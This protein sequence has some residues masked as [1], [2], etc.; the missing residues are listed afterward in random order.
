V[1]KKELF[2]EITKYYETDYENNHN[3]LEFIRN[4]KHVSLTKKLLIK[5]EYGLIGNILYKHRYNNNL[6]ECIYKLEC[7]KILEL[8]K[9]EN[10]SI[11][12]NNYQENFA[13]EDYDNN[14]ILKYIDNS[15]LNDKN[16]MKEIIKYH[17]YILEYVNVEYRKDKEIILEVV[18][19]DGNALEYA[20]DELKIDK[21][22]VLEAIKQTE[23]ALFY[24]SQK[25]KQDEMFI[26]EIVKVNKT[27]IK[28]LYKELYNNKSLVLDIIKQD[29]ISLEMLPEKYKDDKEIVFEAVKQ[30]CNAFQYAADEL[31]ND[32]EFII[33][34]INECS[35]S[36]TILEHIDI[37]LKKDYSFLYQIVNLNYSI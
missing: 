20:A 19:H 2:K 22:I 34:L 33:Y 13:I 29:G 23:N 27:T 16:I 26:L 37:N 10:I 24:I 8:I 9:L 25:L 12:Y 35:S 7:Q 30:N 18:K 14:K 11:K 3:F 28:Y 31:K 6:Y 5:N 21:E 15:I 4:L 32:Q 36:K 1:N 17:N